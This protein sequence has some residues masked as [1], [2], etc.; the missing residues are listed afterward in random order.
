MGQLSAEDEEAKVLPEGED[1]RSHCLR[2]HRAVAAARVIM[3]RSCV[4]TSIVAEP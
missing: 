4:D 3:T 1:V 2:A